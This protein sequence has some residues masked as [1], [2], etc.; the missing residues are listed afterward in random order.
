M[1]WLLVLVPAAVAAV[2]IAKGR[3]GMMSALDLDAMIQKL[4]EGAPPR[5]AYENVK[6]IRGNTERIIE[7][8]ETEMKE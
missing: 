5:W 1:K 7:L 4:P 6:A 2:V 3:R 8:L